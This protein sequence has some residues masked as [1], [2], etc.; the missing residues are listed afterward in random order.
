MPELTTYNIY[1]TYILHITST[2]VNSRVDSNTFTM[3]NPMPESTLTYD[4]VD[5]IPQPGTLDLASVVNKTDCGD[6]VKN[7]RGDR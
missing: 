1:Y 6:S 5:F 3:G 7:L 2:Y 4:R